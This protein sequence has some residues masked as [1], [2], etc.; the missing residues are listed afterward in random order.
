[1]VC[2]RPSS[3]LPATE[4][5]NTSAYVPDSHHLQSADNVSSLHRTPYMHTIPIL[6]YLPAVK[7]SISWRA[8]SSPPHCHSS[9][10]VRP[11]N[12]SLGSQAL[13]RRNCQLLT[14]WKADPSQKLIK[15]LPLQLFTF[16]HKSKPRSF[17][18]PLLRPRFGSTIPRPL[19]PMTWCTCSSHT[20]HAFS[21]II[22]TYVSDRL[23]SANMLLQ[24]LRF[25]DTTPLS[26]LNQ[27]R[28]RGVISCHWR[29]HGTA[30]RRGLN[31]R[32]LIFGGPVSLSTGWRQ[33]LNTALYSLL[34]RMLPWQENQGAFP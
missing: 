20:T 28:C 2:W 12:G 7:Q 4:N 25:P 34:C 13:Q 27:V 33:R 24:T 16:S 21:F 31:P 19:S 5:S 8:A 6:H 14:P 17:P 9:S 30:W 15:N 22:I 18:L 26:A 32:R 23:L 1:M 11:T 29:R 10:S 3:W